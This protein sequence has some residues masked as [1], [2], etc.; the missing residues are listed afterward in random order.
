[1]NSIQVIK[2]GGSSLSDREKI[3]RLCENIKK[4]T[5]K[6]IKTIVIVSAMGKTTDELIFRCSLFSGEEEY[7]K[8][9]ALLLSTG[10]L[11]SSALFSIALNRN[12]V[13]S[14]VLTPSECGFKIKGEFLDSDFYKLEKSILLDNLR[15]YDA[16]VIPGFHGID[17]DNA[18]RLLGRG[19]SDTTAV[20]VASSLGLKQVSIFS[21]VDGVYTADPNFVGKAL[22]LKEIDYKTMQLMAE[23][24]ARVLHNKCVDLAMRNKVSINCMGSFS[25]ASGTLVTELYASKKDPEAVVCDNSKAMVT[26]SGEFNIEELNIIKHYERIIT[27]KNKSIYF[28]PKTEF[29]K[30]MDNLY[31]RIS[32]IKMEYKLNIAKISIVGYGFNENCLFAEKVFC[33]LKK[34][35]V[36]LY[37]YKNRINCISVYINEDLNRKVTELFHYEFIEKKF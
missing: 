8:E 27:D 26:I 23:S 25:K 31:R 33:L 30:F 15:N 11:Q 12:N 37:A 5:Q 22:K 14:T 7:N 3:F 10:E 18:V 16:I 35:N 2:Y 32:D 6:G 13:K 1:M 21:D 20:A 9:K 28:P 29:L 24:G 34:N 17:K 19:G 4:Y 36:E